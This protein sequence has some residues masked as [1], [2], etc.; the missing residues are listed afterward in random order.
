MPNTRTLLLRL[1]TRNV[2]VHPAWATP[3]CLCP[4]YV[5]AAMELGPR[6]E[7]GPSQ[8]YPGQARPPPALRGG[9][10]RPEDLPFAEVNHQSLKE[11]KERPG[12]ALPRQPGFVPPIL[13]S[14][15]CV[16][17]P[18]GWE[19]TDWSLYA[20]EEPGQGDQGIP[21]GTVFAPL[22][23]CSLSLLLQGWG[24]A[25][26]HPGQQQ[27]PESPRVRAVGPGVAG[28]TQGDVE[29]LPQVPS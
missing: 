16:C 18:Q 20:Q 8:G 4:Q 14:D 22:S 6:M 11:S 29:V 9:T 24:D 10:Y 13:W 19:E 17:S 3:R 21:P 26:S 23:P 28:S 25:N 27:L 15:L 7:R 5:K 1:T 12:L 2:S